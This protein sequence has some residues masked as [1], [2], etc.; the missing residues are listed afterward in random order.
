MPNVTFIIL[1]TTAYKDEWAPAHG[2]P[3]GRLTTVFCPAEGVITGIKY[4]SASRLD[5]ITFICTSAIGVSELGP[6][7]GTGGVAGEEKCPPGSYISSIHGRSA[8]RVDSLGIQCWQFSQ[9]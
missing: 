3:G 6:F 2:G 8:N 9:T 1:I 4:R 5:S 7:G